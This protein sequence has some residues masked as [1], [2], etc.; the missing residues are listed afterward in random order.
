MEM[1]MPDWVEFYNPQGH[2]EDLTGWQL[3]VYD[4]Y[5]E[6][7]ALYT[8]PTFTLQSGAYVVL[9]EGYGLDTATD[10]YTADGNTFPWGNA[11]SGAAGL[12]NAS[13]AG[14]DFVRW[15]TSTVAAPAGTGWGGENPSGPPVGL[16]LGRDEWSTDTDQGSDWSWQ[17]G[18]PGTENGGA[19]QC[20]GLAVGVEPAGAGVVG[21]TPEANCGMSQYLL[22]MQVTLTANSA[23]GYTFSYWSGALGGSNP[24]AYLLLNEAKSVTAHFVS[25]LPTATPTPS[26]RRLWLPVIM[27]APAPTVSPTLSPS[28]THTVT[29]TWTVRRLWLPLIIRAAAPTPRWTQWIVNP[30]FETDEAWQIPRTEYPAG[31][32]YSR[33]HTGMRSMRLGIPAGGNLYSYSSAQQAVDLPAS[34][35]EATLTFYYWPVTA[36]PD[37]DRIY[38]CVLRASDD[39]ALQTTVW[40][41]YEQAWHQRSFDLGA[42]AGQ[43][44]KVHFGVKNDGENWITSVYLDDVELWVRW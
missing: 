24:V 25:A 26:V 28:P 22:G 1:G 11:D 4:A 15:G 39:V 44:I 5:D 31:Y 40:T 13:R 27:R 2:A 30:S 12:V 33:P 29:P 35:T 19:L 6:L 3:W 8:F 17:L 21:V 41:D 42:Y 34:A 16:T 23:L 38:F 18:T 7:S 14:I 36:W 32:S 20:V 43:R 37:T 10:L 9:H